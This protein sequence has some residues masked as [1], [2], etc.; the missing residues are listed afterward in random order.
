MSSAAIAA[1]AVAVV[2]MAAACGDDDGESSEGDG[3]ADEVTVV[4]LETFCEDVDMATMEQVIDSGGDDLPDL[5]V[6]EEI[7]DDW[8][9]AV[10][11]DDDART[12]VVDFYMLECQGSVPLDEDS[13]LDDGRVY[14]PE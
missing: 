2:M 6:P 11:G 12:R 13:G 7:A 4:D 9:D 5:A 10:D 14:V 8:A 3:G 1:V